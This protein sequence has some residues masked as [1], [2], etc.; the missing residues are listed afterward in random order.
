MTSPARLNLI[1]PISHPLD[2]ALRA[3]F[4]SLQDAAQALRQDGGRMG[5]WR[6][7]GSALNARKALTSHASAC[8]SVNGPL[9]HIVDARPRLRPR[10]QRCLNDHVRLLTLVDGIIHDARGDAGAGPESLRNRAIACSTAVA[11]HGRRVRTTAFEWAYR[12]I[13]GEAG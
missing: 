1:A 10:V 5:L 4:V 13:G 6:Y 12:D 2:P 3:A 7:L 9:L 8:G 11:A